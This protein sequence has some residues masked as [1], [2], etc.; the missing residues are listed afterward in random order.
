M[1]VKTRH[2]NWKY[3]CKRSR[4]HHG[5]VHIRKSSHSQIIHIGEQHIPISRLTA[6]QSFL[7]FGSAQGI[8][9]LT[10]AC[11][12]HQIAGNTS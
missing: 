5:P 10:S 7:K 6:D 9:F 2:D 8:L 4:S 1:R 3:N 11:F 12:F